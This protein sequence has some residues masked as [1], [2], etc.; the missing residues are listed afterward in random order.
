MSTTISSTTLKT[1]VKIAQTG[2]KKFEFNNPDTGLIFTVRI[3]TKKEHEERIKRHEQ[4]QEEETTT[5]TTKLTASVGGPS[6]AGMR[7]HPGRRLG[8]LA[9]V[10]SKFDMKSIMEQQQ[11]EKE[12]LRRRLSGSGAKKQQQQP[13]VEKK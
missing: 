4:Q 9:E 2:I 6:V 1:F 3:E 12:E 11:K 7:D 8:T 10:Q 13:P 5:T